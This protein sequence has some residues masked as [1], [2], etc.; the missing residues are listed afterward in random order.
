MTW[1]SQLVLSLLKIGIQISL[2]VDMIWILVLHLLNFID[3]PKPW[4]TLFRKDKC[5]HTSWSRK[6]LAFFSFWL[7]LDIYTSLLNLYS[8]YLTFI[9]SDTLEVFQY[10]NISYWNHVHHFLCYDTLILRGFAN[11]HTSVLISAH[12]WLIFWT[13][14][15]KKNSIT[16]LMDII[17]FL[18]N[19]LYVGCA[20]WDISYLILVTFI[21]L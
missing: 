4:F 9:R 10:S 21:G 16:C 2:D 14:M 17:N 8:T 13:S 1:L 3:L 15:C 6:K 19:N 18:I 11:F 5:L 12:D 7:K 20:T